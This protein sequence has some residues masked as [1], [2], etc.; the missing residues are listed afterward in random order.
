MNKTLGD[1][2]KCYRCAAGGVVELVLTPEIMHY[3]KYI[4]SKCGW[5]IQWA[6]NP[7]ATHD[8]LMTGLETDAP[9]IQFGKHKGKNVSDVPGSY[10]QWVYESDFP[11]PIQ[12]VAL[13]ELIK[14][15]I[16]N[17]RTKF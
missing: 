13:D 9:I 15:G 10:L 2:I 17:V 8:H 3:G 5:F 4:C 12:Q 11:E 7:N 16:I 14:R 1:G 6:K